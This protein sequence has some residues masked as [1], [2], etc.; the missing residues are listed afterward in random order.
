MRSEK[1]VRRRKMESYTEAETVNS[2]SPSAAAFKNEVTDE[3]CPHSIK[4][5]FFDTED[6]VAVIR[7]NAEGAVSYKACVLSPQ[8]PFNYYT[9]DY[10][11]GLQLYTSAS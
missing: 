6:P 5:K 3:E 1:T 4:K 10:E 9:R 8:A 7:V 2:G 11:A